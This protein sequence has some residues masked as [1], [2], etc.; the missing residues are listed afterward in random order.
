MNWKRRLWLATL[1]LAAVLGAWMALV[2]AMVISTI[3]DVHRDTFVELALSRWPLMALGWATGVLGSFVFLRWASLR[4]LRLP[5]RMAERVRA[6]VA[7]REGSLRLP[8]TRGQDVEELAAAINEL[9]AQRE[10]GRKELVARVAEASQKLQT[11]RNRLAALLGEL[12]EA[13]IVCT[14]DG[15]VALYNRRARLQCR[16]LSDQ[17]NVAGGADLLGIGRSIFAVFDRELIAHALERIGQRLDRGASRPTAQF[18][19]SSKAGQ[20]LRV[21]VA[22]VLADDGGDAAA[23]AQ[24]QGYVLLLENVTRAHL[25]GAAREATLN[26]LATRASASLARVRELL[27]AGAGADAAQQSLEEL[28]AAIRDWAEEGGRQLRQRWPLEEVLAADFLR[29]AARRMAVF[30]GREPAVQSPDDPLWLRLDSFAMIQGLS[31][32]AQRLVDEYQVRYLRLRVQAAQGLA[33]LDLVWAG[34]ALNTETAMT[35]GSEPITEGGSATA[36]TLREIVD[37]HG[38][39]WW[40]ERDRIHNEGFFRFALPLVPA[41]E[42]E[43]AAAEAPDGQSRPEY[44]DFDLFAERET[45]AALHDRPLASLVYCVFDT[46]TT[47]LN[48]SEGDEIIQLGAV[49][50]FNGRILRQESFEQLVDPGRPIPP[51]TIPIHGITPDMVAGRP[52]IESVLPAFHRFARDTVL[53]AHNAAFDMK[54]LQLLEGRTGLRFEQ[55]VL[56]T[57]LLSAVVNPQQ[58]SHRLEALAERFSIPVLGRHTALGDALVTAEVLVRLIPMLQAQ[59]I[60]TLGQ[61]LEASRRTY[62]ARLKY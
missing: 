46:E 59:G 50:V 57:L 23:H 48:P 41:L 25:E 43:A 36:L 24:L 7:D 38:A 8:V 31:Y 15:R 56:D 58:D 49:R 9:A 39:Q 17:P 37:R 22:P 18:V 35:W 42:A 5:A 19:T 12:T 53:V 14:A 33:H 30:S 40:F 20:L 61:A 1:V 10:E 51:A 29:A 2:A 3:D 44:F 45:T 60:H 47:G 13:V 62:F 4:W 6:L 55:P 28:T 21:Q 34:Q 11:E 52:R 27:A 32:L 26:A 16:A 54:F